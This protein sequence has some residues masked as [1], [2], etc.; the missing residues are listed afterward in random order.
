[1]NSNI[2]NL[3]SFSTTTQ[4]HL[5]QNQEEKRLEGKRTKRKISRQKTKRQFHCRTSRLKAVQVR[6]TYSAVSK[7]IELGSPMLQSVTQRALN[8]ICHIMFFAEHLS[9]KQE[10]EVSAV[11]HFFT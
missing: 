9:R 4:T 11:L 2:K 7:M 3:L 1:M 8:N 6:E 10:K 5:R